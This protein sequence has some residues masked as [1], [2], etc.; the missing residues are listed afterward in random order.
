[1]QTYKTG[2]YIAE[3]LYY[4]GIL[5]H[6]EYQNEY[7]VPNVT[8]YEMVLE[9]FKEINNFDYSSD[10][11]NIVHNYYTKSNVEELIENFFKNIVQKFPGN[12]FKNANES[13]YHGLLFHILWN[14]TNRNTFEVLPEYNLP[15]GT[16]DVILR[17]FPKARVRQKLNDIFEIKQVPKSAKE[18]EF[19]AQFEKVKI[20]AKKHLTG[21]YKNWR[22]VAVCFRGNKDY[23]IKIF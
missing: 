3:G 11:T 13:F 4:S 7:H 8:T 16:V 9:Y 22:A 21:D 2:R 18:S 15:T 5:T 23:K 14:T 12:F 20:Q 1:M 10:L 6:S 17:S 19:N